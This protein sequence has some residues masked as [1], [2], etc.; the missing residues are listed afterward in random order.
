MLVINLWGGPGAGKSTVA[1]GLFVL[2]R[3]HTKANCE[4]TNEFATELCFERA[5]DNLKDQVYLLGN[6]FHRLWRLE[7]LGVDVAISDSPLGSGIGHMKAK[8]KPTFFHE[9]EALTKKLADEFLNTHIFLERDIYAEGG[10]KG[11]KATGKNAGWLRNLDTQIR[12]VAD[13]VKVVTYGPQAIEEVFKY[14]VPMVTDYLLPKNWG[15]LHL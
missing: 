15:P 7:Q 12:Q 5:K 8:G 4:L 3:Q 13:P 11:N 6:Q 1:A 9:Y 14:V 2:L 10:F